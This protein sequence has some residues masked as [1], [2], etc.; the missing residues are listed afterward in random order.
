MKAHTHDA[1]DSLLPAADA[2]QG[3][4]AFTAHKKHSDPGP[5]SA[6]VTGFFYFVQSY[7]Y[8]LHFFLKR[9]PHAAVSLKQPL[10][11]HRPRRQ[12]KP[13]PPNKI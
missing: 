5:N 13:K 10:P 12:K 6:S 7:K 8:K 4:E 9:K 1:F 2:S 3:I 11:V